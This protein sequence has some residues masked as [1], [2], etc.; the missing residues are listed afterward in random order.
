MIKTLIFL[1]I[2]LTYWANVHGIGATL[3][4]MFM[5]LFFLI[6]VI[7]LV[8]SRVERIRPGVAEAVLYGMATLSAAVA[9]CRDIESCLTYSV[10]FFI[11]LSLISVLVRTVSLE[12]LLDIGAAAALVMVVSTVIFEHREL[13]RALAVTISKNGL[14]RLW[15]YGNHPNL[16]GYIFGA[17]SLL[18]ARRAILSRHW[19]ERILMGVCVVL[20]W[21]LIIAA[22]ARASLLA[23]I[24]AAI[25][26]VIAEV[27][28]T[29]KAVKTFLAAGLALIVCVTA[30]TRGAAF[31]Y[32][33]RILDLNSRTRGVSSGASGRTE[34]WHDAFVALTT[35]PW[36]L[37]LGGSLRSS[38][39]S[40]IGFD[41]TENSYITIL[42]DSG[43]FMGVAVCL[44]FIMA[45]FKA[46]TLSRASGADRPLALLLLPSFFVFLL[47]EA[48]F[49]RY[50]LG[51][52][53]PLSLLSLILVLSLSVRSAQLEA[54]LAAVKDPPAQQPD[55]GAAYAGTAQSGG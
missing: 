34:S 2:V 51:I 11:T 20:A 42:L 12:E 44:V 13:Q 3:Q 55:G 35:D 53:N 48:I 47:F 19:L 26:A 14:Y 37:A 31:T 22:S 1:G 32:L 16:G 40:V 4:P 27:R 24:A 21:A 54:R 49:N 45:P 46:W 8:Q 38:D 15:P 39:V 17:G 41:A 28:W 50:L 33:A 52:G 36:R 43:L 6:A 10:A 5:L 9:M 18:L 29:K 23:L 25:T 30:A 7:A